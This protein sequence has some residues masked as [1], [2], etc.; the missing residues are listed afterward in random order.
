MNCINQQKGENIIQ[1]VDFTLKDKSDIPKALRHGIY[2]PV[3]DKALNL[4][5]QRR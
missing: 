3:K 2:Q 4:K 5:N 1:N